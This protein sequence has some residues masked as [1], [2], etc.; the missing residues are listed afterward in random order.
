MVGIKEGG[1]MEGN[2]GPPI[3]G[4]DKRGP[5]DVK[6]REMKRRAK[7]DAKRGLCTASRLDC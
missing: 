4:N 3:Q 7:R 1:Y 5:F 6:R 2:Y